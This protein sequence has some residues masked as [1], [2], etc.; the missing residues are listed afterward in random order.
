[1]IKLYDGGA[2][3]IDGKTIIPE[4]ESSFAAEE[5]KKAKAGTMA[6]AILTAHNTS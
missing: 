4:G 2:Y 3:L 1:M 5:K 6:H